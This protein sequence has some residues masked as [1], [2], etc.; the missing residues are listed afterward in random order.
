M[1][2]FERAPFSFEFGD[3]ADRDDSEH[4]VLAARQARFL[5]I[6][7]LPFEQLQP[8]QDLPIECRI[9]FYTNRVIMPPVFIQWAA[10]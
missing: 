7:P 10:L 1:N 6:V 8:L 4:D 3:S 5:W 2:L 9:S